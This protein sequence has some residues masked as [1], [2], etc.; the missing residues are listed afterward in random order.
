[1]L[2][3]AVRKFP[4]LLTRKT[5]GIV[6]KAYN[7][8]KFFLKLSLLLHTRLSLEN[9]IHIVFRFGLDIKWILSYFQKELIFDNIKPTIFFAFVV[10]G[11]NPT[12]VMDIFVQAFPKYPNSNFRKIRHL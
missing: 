3:K 2:R 11:S 8:E 12:R 9:K 1:M 5:S 7:S 4:Q 6:N 10:K